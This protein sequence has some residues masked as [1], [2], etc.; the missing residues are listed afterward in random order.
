[1]TDTKKSLRGFAA[2]SPE[3]RAAIAS[4]GGKAVHAKGTGHELNSETG[5]VAGRK[6]GLVTSANREHMREIGRRGGLKRAALA[7]EAEASPEQ[8]PH[9]E[10]YYSS[11]RMA[12]AGRID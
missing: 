9:T 2:M 4:K 7:R 6:G 12:A 3:K 10:N 1:M 5:R 11:E 8:E